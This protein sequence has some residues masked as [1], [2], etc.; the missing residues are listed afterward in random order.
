MNIMTE[1]NKKAENHIENI[2]TPTPT[3]I[4]NSQN[5]LNK[6]TPGIFGGFLDKLADSIIETN[7]S[8]MGHT[9]CTT[10]PPSKLEGVEPSKVE[11]LS[12]GAHGESLTQLESFLI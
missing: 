3:P 1:Q 11:E 7:P 12:F 5:I 9:Q 6:V 4:D 8:P 10:D 2:T